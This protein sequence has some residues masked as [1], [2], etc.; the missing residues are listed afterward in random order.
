MTY[1]TPELDIIEFDSDDTIMTSITPDND[2]LP[3]M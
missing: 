1:T 2:E 3:L